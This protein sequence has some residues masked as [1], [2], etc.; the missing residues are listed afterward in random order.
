MQHP[1]RSVAEQR[2]SITGFG[3]MD[4]CGDGSAFSIR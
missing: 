1:L 3:F 4:S 2:A